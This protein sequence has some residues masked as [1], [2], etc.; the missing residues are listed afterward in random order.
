MTGSSGLG[1]EVI[2]IDLAQRS[3]VMI[4]GNADVLILAKELDAL[5]GVRAVANDI[6]QAPDTINPS[7]L[8]DIVEHCLEGSQITV[9]VGDNR[10]AHVCH[11]LIYQF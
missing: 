1:I 3:P 5:P 4:A 2:Q 9:D 7:P 6:S 10:K 11:W 8:I